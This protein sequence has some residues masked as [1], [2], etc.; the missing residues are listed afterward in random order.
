M[1]RD[2]SEVEK[3]PR[4]L[5]IRDVIFEVLGGG[6]ILKIAADCFALMPLDIAL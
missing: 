3:H 6:T 1:E 2:A 5:C 4:W